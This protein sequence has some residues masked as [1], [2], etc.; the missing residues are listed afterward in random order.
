MVRRQII[1][2]TG[3]QPAVVQPTVSGCT[4]RSTP[5]CTTATAVSKLAEE[6]TPEYTFLLSFQSAENYIRLY[7]IYRVFMGNTIFH[8]FCIAY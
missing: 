4:A 5:S 3:N 6:N 2:S 1:V 8:I 7:I